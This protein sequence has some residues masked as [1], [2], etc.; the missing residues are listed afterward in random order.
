MLFLYFSTEQNPSY[1]VRKNDA[2]LAFS[3]KEGVEMKR[4]IED[5]RIR[6]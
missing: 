1:V 4:E 6:A 5:G 3:N 2:L